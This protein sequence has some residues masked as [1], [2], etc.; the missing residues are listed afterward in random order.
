MILFENTTRQYPR[1]NC[2]LEVSRLQLLLLLSSRVL[3]RTWLQN[4]FGITRTRGKRS[5]WWKH[6]SQCHFV[7]HKFHL[8][9]PCRERPANNSLCN[10]TDKLLK[11]K[12]YKYLSIRGSTISETALRLEVSNPRPFVLLVRAHVHVEGYAAFVEG[13]QHEKTEVLRG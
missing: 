10:G 13:Y 3:W 6:C 4:I 5:S 7:Y 8:K 2:L 12:K 1:R 11:E 9:W